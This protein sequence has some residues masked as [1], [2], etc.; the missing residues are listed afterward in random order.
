M[1]LQKYLYTEKTV[2]NVLE[3]YIEE[4]LDTGEITSII[5]ANKLQS[6]LNMIRDK[7]FLRD[8]RRL[9][10]ETYDLLDKKHPDLHF[11]I[12]G[13]R[14]SLISAENKIILY[15]SMNKSLDLIRDFFAF[16]II[17]FGDTSLDLTG[18]CYKIIED[19]I[20]FAAKKGFTPCDRLPLIDPKSLDTHQNDYFSKFKYKQFVKD[21]IC[22][23]KKNG[24]QS[25]HLVLVDTQGRH[26]EIQVR[27]LDMHTMAEAG[28]AEHDKYKEKKY[29]QDFKF[30]RSKV[31]IHGYSFYNGKVFDFA[32]V[33]KPLKVFQ[34]QQT[35]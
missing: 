2:P 16:R 31:Q 4:L 7:A 17:L 26:L 6:Y 14:K 15:N 13:R 25:I 23:P 29:C 18:H 12:D 35:F 3:R 11:Y 21:Y 34:R 28:D 33:E 9:F 32:G 20:D 19:I 1:S 27:T 22:F 24:Y 30:D 5:H 10:N 8:L